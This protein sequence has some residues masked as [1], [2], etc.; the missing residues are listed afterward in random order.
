MKRI[1]KNIRNVKQQGVVLIVV[2]IMLVV[3]TVLGVHTMAMASL[4]VQMS[5]NSQSMMNTFQSAESG[6]VG[7][8]G[9]EE[10]FV[11]AINLP[12]DESILRDYEMGNY[13]A[14][15]STK[16]TGAAGSMEGYSLNTFVGY[17][18]SIS[19]SAEQQSTG[20]RTRLVQAV[21]HLAPGKVN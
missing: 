7:T 3:L 8:L 4:E 6:I 9:E 21:K 1:Q 20:A 16:L 15:T 2:L 5:S 12:P 10:I 13:T 11:S 14:S 18:F 19:A 17:P